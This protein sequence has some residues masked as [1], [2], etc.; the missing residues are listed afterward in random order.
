[1]SGLPTTFIYPEWVTDNKYDELA[2]WVCLTL[3]HYLFYLVAIRV[4][5]PLVGR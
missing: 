3:G 2:L 4:K 1:M 5:A